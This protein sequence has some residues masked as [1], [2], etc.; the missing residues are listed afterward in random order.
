MKKKKTTP[1]RRLTGRVTTLL[2]P[3]AAIEGAL[4]FEETLRLDGRVKGRIESAAGAL[5]IG[6]TA[7]V[8]AEIRAGRVMVMGRVTG[9][10]EAGERIDVFA[11]GRVDGRMYS[12][13]IAIDPGASFNGGC[14]ARRPPEA[15]GEGA[16]HFSKNL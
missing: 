14:G 6:E 9:V 4:F 1:D 2:G 13:V 5:I 8:E 10:I 11:S 16:Q 7:V 12:P 3:D 15:E